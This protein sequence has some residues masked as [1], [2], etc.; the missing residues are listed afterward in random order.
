MGT[1]LLVLLSRMAGLF[2]CHRADEEFDAEIAEHL[3]MLADENIRRGMPPEEA[4]RVARRS[5]GRI[6]RVKEEQREQRGLPRFELLAGDCRY[7]VRTLRQNPGFT[8]VAVATLALGIGINTAVFTVYDAIALKPLPVADPGRVVRFERWFENRGL[9]NVQYAFSYPEYAYFL[10]HDRS[11]SGLVAASWPAQMATASEKLTVQL[12]SGN[13]F[14]VLGI[15][16]VRGRNFDSRADS[17]SGE[18]NVIVISYKL[19]KG[20]FNL[21]PGVV[22][23]TLR[24]N[25]AVL[26]II[27]VA[28]EPFT[29]T[30]VP[31]Q[32][33]DFW[34]PLAAQQL[35]APGAD[36]RH[37]PDNAQFVILG[38][39]APNTTQG[40]AQ[41]ESDVLM[42]RFASSRRERVRTTALTLQRLTYFGN[43]EDPRFQALAIGLMLL[44]GLVLLIACANLANMLLARG[45]ARQREFAVRLALGASRRRLIRQL[46]TESCLLSLLGGGAGFF[47]SGACIRMVSLTTLG[48]YAIEAGLSFTPD[49]RIFLYTLLLA[50]AAGF[51][52]GLSPAL[53]YSRPNLTSALKQEGATFGGRLARSRLRSILVACQVA[54]SMLLLIIA[55]LLLRGMLR[56]NDAQPGFDVRRVYLVNAEFASLPEKAAANEQLL[57]ARIAALPQVAAISQ[58]SAPMMGTWTPPIFTSGLRART[59]ASYAGTNYFETLGVPLIRGRSFTDEDVRLSAALAVISENAARQFW[60]GEDPIGKRF[61]LDMHFNGTLREF[62]VIGIVRD[63]R[64]ANLSRTD[65]AHVYLPA[66]PAQ[67]DWL[68]VRFQ[69]DPMAAIGPLRSAVAAFDRGLLRSLYLTSIEEGPLHVQRLLAG[70]YALFAIVLAVLALILAAV[71]IYGVMS[72]LVGRRVREI[73]VLMALGADGGDVLRSVI[74]HGLHPVMIGCVFGLIG[75]AAASRLIHSTLTFPGSEDFLYG[76]PWFDPATFA[77][78]TIFVALIAILASAVPARRALK[79]DPAV[80]LRCE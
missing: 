58:G 71:G 73:G 62:E 10:E 3:E 63:V 51:A 34:A 56:A 31:P 5:F 79:V 41:A 68:L 47:F 22:G 45:A 52:F 77:G 25:D 18:S 72:Y 13:Y 74:L 48:P 55:G 17:E 32:A 43:T 60:P 33:P 24:V 53:Q 59:L 26:T 65:P 6:T 30:S 11:F 39:V 15:N 49:T 75:A 57:R 27:G 2:R 50:L 64:Y 36:W 29:G 44:V 12:V 16:P 4:R 69:G 46:L 35:L 28:P 78:L 20:R 80:A 38:R 21:D 66:D 40:L 67:P 61:K 23:R 1:K 8:L 76:L 70:V 37:D 14:D 54:A 9:G 42:R 7:A 19:W